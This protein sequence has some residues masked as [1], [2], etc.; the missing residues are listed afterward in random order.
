MFGSQSARRL[1]GTAGLTARTDFDG[2][3]QKR[4][5][6]L[7]SNQRPS[8]YESPALTTELQAHELRGKTRTLNTRINS[9]LLC[10]LS[11]RKG[12]QTLPAGTRRSEAT[13]EGGPARVETSCDSG[14]ITI[15]YPA[16]VATADAVINAV[17][18][19]GDRRDGQARPD[20]SNRS[21]ITNM[22]AAMVSNS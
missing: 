2:R 15:T 10:R 1:G 3:G 14:Y 22:F 4:W 8:D 11:Y 19:L 6:R 7:G 12:R 17:V 20:I 18:L 13:T 21:A 16:P 9:P 5:A